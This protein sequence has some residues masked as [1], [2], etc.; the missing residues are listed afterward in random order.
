MMHDIVS[1]NARHAATKTPRRS[2]LIVKRILDII[3]SAVLLVLLSPLLLIVTVMA[4]IDTHGAPFFVQTRM[5]RGGKSFRMIKFRT[6]SVDAPPDV[7]T[8]CL[9][10]AD[11]YISDIGH[12]LR[13]YSLDELPQLWNVLKG[14][15]SFIGPRP[16]VLTEEDLLDMRALH[17]AGEVRPGITGFAQV[18]GRDN[19]P[20]SQKA[21][22]DG[23]YARHATFVMDMRILWQTV[24]YVMRSEGVVEGAN[25]RVSDR[26]SSTRSA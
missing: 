3:F 19:L 9:E 15:M 22:L 8:H 1:I 13:K 23:Y 18:R 4:A 16:V 12:F 11:S 24:S 14:D 2:F 7:A 6:M 21:F 10:N 20:I 26:K 25:E 5:G 17:G